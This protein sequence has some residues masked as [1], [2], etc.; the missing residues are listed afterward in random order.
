ML[1]G[2]QAFRGRQWITISNVRTAHPTGFH[3]PK[4]PVKLRSHTKWE[5][6]FPGAEHT[7]GCGC[8]PPSLPGLCR[9]SRRS[10]G[11]APHRPKEQ[12]RVRG[13]G[14]QTPVQSSHLTWC[15]LW[16]L[17]CSSAFPSCQGTDTSVSD[18]GLY[19]TTAVRAR[20]EFLGLQT[21]L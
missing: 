11:C 12:T 15:S 16:P 3:V 1:G 10:E 5:I 8:F 13:Q 9:I 7:P 20:P 21:K 2:L 18:S 6:R 14:S 19:H 4:P 17:I